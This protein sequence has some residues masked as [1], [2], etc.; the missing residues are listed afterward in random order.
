MG[1]TC[2]SA[3][4]AGTAAGTVTG[5]FGGG[6]GMVLIPLLTALTDLKEEEV[7][8]TSI[9]VIAPV[10]L[11]C[12]GLTAQTTPLP[13]AASVPWLLGSAAGGVLAGLL[14]KR[15]PVLWLHRGLGTLILW[16]GWRYLW[17]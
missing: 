17:S 10:C 11:V 4:A 9:S 2:M 14:G 5:L 8:P 12:L 7:F 3:L 16:G 6:G 13:W 1:K 15:I